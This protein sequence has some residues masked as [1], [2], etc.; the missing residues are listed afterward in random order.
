MVAAASEARPS[1][2]RGD[3]PKQ[4]RMQAARQLLEA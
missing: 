1:L 2:S 4:S 3:I